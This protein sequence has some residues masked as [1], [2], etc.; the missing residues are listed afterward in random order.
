[1]RWDGQA[2][3]IG[4][5]RVVYRVLMG[6]IEGRSSLGR[7]RRRWEDKIKMDL[8]EVGWVYGLV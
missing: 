7:S 6:E 3:R 1:M 2:A 4:N 8:Q 5:R